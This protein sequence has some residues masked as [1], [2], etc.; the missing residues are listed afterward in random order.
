[1]IPSPSPT[2]NLPP[3]GWEREIP[4]YRAT[5]AVH[6][7]PNKRFKLEKPFSS[8]SDNDCWQYAERSVA[9]GEVITTT[10]WPHQSFR[11]L[12]FAA[13]KVLAFFNGA[14]RSRLTLSPWHAGAVRLDN[15]MSDAPAIFDV[16]PPQIKPVDLRPS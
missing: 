4:K 16:R 5:R 10:A 3:L 14:L 8:C 7:S 13:E 15:G 12:N 6:P 2:D 9:A 1:V 11:P